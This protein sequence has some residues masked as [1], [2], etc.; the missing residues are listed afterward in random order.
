MF[1]ADFDLGVFQE[2]KVTRRDHTRESSRYRVVMTDPPILHRG[3]VA[4]FYR[5]AGHFTLEAL[6]LHVTNL[7]RFHMATGQQWWNAVRCY[8][9]T[10]DTSAIEDIVTAI[11]RRPQGAKLLVSVNFDTD[12]SNP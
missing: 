12:L 10:N 1:Q 3:S 7:N 6:C 9:S 11:R 4:V 2:T 8:I 5:E